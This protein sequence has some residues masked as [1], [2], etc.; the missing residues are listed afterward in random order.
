MQKSNIT[1][2][3]FTPAQ[4]GETA[5][6][7]NGVRLPIVG[8]FIS[9]DGSYSLPCF[10]TVSD[11]KWQLNC[12]I[13]RLFHPEKYAKEFNEDVQEHIRYLIKWLSE[14]CKPELKE[15]VL[16]ELNE[17][18]K[19]VSELDGEDKHMAELYIKEYFKG[20]R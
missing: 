8:S 14:H 12:L 20:V 3:F 13:D 19:Y 6:I 4:E 2:L 1:K 10:E 11:Y 5:E 18:V 7:A 17:L 9:K 15:N 16:T